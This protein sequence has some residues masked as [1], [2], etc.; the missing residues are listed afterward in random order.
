MGRAVSCLDATLPPKT[1]QLLHA[2]YQKAKH[3]L[4]CA[5]VKLRKSASKEYREQYFN[6]IDT[7]E[8]NQQLGLAVPDL[9]PESQKPG[10]VVHDSEERRL[11]AAILCDQTPGLT[12]EAR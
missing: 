10:V 3:A 12:E 1:S 4:K 11:I 6:T 7:K 2:K 8:V 5:R 9:E